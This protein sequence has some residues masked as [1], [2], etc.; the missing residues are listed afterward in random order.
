MF[1]FTAQVFDL[2]Y[3]FIITFYSLISLL[4]F[5]TVVYQERS[6]NHKLNLIQQFQYHL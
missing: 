4:D 5:S 2:F 6:G 1:F 3:E